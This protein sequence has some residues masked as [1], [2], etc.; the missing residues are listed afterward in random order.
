M[1]FVFRRVLFFIFSGGVTYGLYICI[2]N[3]KAFNG[4]SIYVCV[5]SQ[6]DSH[7]EVISRVHCLDQIEPAAAL[8]SELW[9][10]VE[11]CKEDFLNLN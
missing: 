7:N 10:K 9:R 8:I 2:Y 11:G 3:V 6:F 4:Y 5:R 1:L